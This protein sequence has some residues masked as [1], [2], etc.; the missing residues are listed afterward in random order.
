M[1]RRPG[2]GVFPDLHVFPGGKVDNKDVELAKAFNSPRSNRRAYWLPEFE[3]GYWVAAVRECFEEAGVLFARRATSPIQ[4]KERTSWR[5]ELLSDKQDL[6]E[7]LDAYGLTI[8]YSNLH[9]FSH[10]ITPPRAPARFNVRFFVAQLPQD[11]QADFHASETVSGEWITPKEALYKQASGEWQMIVPTLTT[12]R[13]IAGSTDTE[14]LVA[15]IQSGRHRIPVT[16]DLHANGLQYFDT[17]K[18]P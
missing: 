17:R 14:Q 3:D 2:R 18:F 13:M 9:Y 5:E 12:L 1:L 8:E 11:Q 16:K 4:S 10:W 15:D 7:M 6:A